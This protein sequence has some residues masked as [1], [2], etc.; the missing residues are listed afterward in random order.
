MLGLT[1]GE[2]DIAETCPSMAI[3]MGEETDA[4]YSWV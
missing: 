1:L 4:D 3:K 2:K